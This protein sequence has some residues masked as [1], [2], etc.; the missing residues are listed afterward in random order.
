MNDHDRNMPAASTSQR[1]TERVRSALSVWTTAALLTTAVGTMLGCSTPKPARDLAAQGAVI[2]DRS[3]TETL[4][5]IQR[6]NQAYARREAILLRLAEGDIRDRS[7]GD[8]R[9]WIDAQAGVV[10]YQK[11]ID[12]LVRISDRSRTT[13][14]QLA[15]DLAAKAKQIAVAAGPAASAPSANIAEAKKTFIVLSQELTAEEWLKL[16]QAYVKQVQADLKAL[17][18]PAAAASA[19]SSPT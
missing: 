13:R 16:G 17:N 5:F 12:T 2:A 10:N 19:A 9:A 3:E 18:A 4:A 6:A 15:T 14:E 7:A 1:P 8:F 11:D